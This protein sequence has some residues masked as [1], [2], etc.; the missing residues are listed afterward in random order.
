LAR[1]S[2]KKEGSGLSEQARGSSIA[3]G[4]QKLG[5]KAAKDEKIRLCERTMSAG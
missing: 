5:E 3:P 4:A 2:V 1:S